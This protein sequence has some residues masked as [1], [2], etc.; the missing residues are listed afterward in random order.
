M[1]AAQ[2]DVNSPILGTIFAIKIKQG[3]QVRVGQEIIIIESMKMEHPI[4]ADV[5]GTVI[6]IY[7]SEGDTISAAQPLF[8]IEPGVVT[9]VHSEE[10]TDTSSSSVRADLA[11]YRE[12]RHLTTDDARPEA[13]A[14]RAAK[15]QRTA[16]ANI[17][18]LVDDGSFMEYGSFAIAAQR[19]RR[20]LDDLIHNTPAD[21]LVGGLACGECGGGGAGVVGGRHLARSGA[22]AHLDHVEHRQS[23]IAK[24]QPGSDAGARA[25]VS[26]ARQVVAGRGDTAGAGPGED[27]GSSLDCRAGRGGTLGG[28]PIAQDNCSIGQSRF[29]GF[30]F[31]RAGGYGPR[32]ADKWS[33]DR[34]E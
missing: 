9:T 27:A 32:F 3:D 17:A 2:H 4:E 8:S 15:G 24:A 6:A 1:A 34:G 28:G 10:V 11:K 25:E 7:V 13:V 5:D 26:A 16:R 19:Q 21:G 22:V 31:A 30:A 14:R 23:Q 29:A 12:R 20:T 18:D 33:V